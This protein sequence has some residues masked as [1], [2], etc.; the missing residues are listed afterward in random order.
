MMETLN[1]SINF[2]LFKSLFFMV[3][4]WL[5]H[6]FPTEYWV[7]GIF[8]RTN[9]AFGENLSKSKTEETIVILIKYS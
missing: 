2:I 9:T 4:I 7:A 8:N 5:F 3:M 6:C 1:S